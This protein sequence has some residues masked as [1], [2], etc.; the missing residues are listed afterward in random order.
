LGRRIL[1]SS[2]IFQWRELP[3]TKQERKY[4]I[5]DYTQVGLQKDGTQMGRPGLIGEVAF[6]TIG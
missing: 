4:T 5:V 2:P 1:N 3:F 6:Q